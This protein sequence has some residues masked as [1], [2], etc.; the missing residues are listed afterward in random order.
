LIENIKSY[1][2]PTTEITIYRWKKG[3]ITLYCDY[4]TVELHISIL[5]NESLLNITYLLETSSDKKQFQ[6]LYTER[7]VE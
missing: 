5:L 2:N 4:L 7:H 3:L 1:Q 6:E